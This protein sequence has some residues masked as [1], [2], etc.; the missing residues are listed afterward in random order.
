MNG[1]RKQQGL[2]EEREDEHAPVWFDHDKAGETAHRT[3]RH[4]HAHEGEH[5][6]E[7][8][9]PHDHEHEHDHDQHHDHEHGQDHDHDEDH[10]GGH[11][12]DHAHGHGHHHHHTPAVGHGRAF[13]LAVVLNVVIVVVQAIYGVLAHSTALLADAGHNL[14]DVL[15][16]LLAWG[17]AWLA[18]R[19]PSARYTFGFGSSSILASLANAALLLVACGAIIMEAVDRLIS[20]APV[21]GFDVFV[22]ATLGMVVNGFSAWLFMRGQKED[23]NI[24]GAFL[25]MAA[26]AGVSAAVAVS[27]LVILATGMTWIDPVMSILV[28]LVILYGTWGL[29]RESV[30]LALAAVP[31]GVDMERIHAFLAAQDGVTDVHDLHVWALSTTGN[32]L[33]VHLVMP[34]G[35]PGDDVLDGIVHTLGTRYRMKH[36]TLQ[37]DM[38]TSGHRCALDHPPYPH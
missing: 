6:H 12:H 36:V 8:G 26:D 14:S 16:L 3:G 11:G 18:T 31:Q 1:E 10:D 27:G 37:V 25:H 17:A 9:H 38:G 35:H 19:R 20:P 24:R 15:G 32:A 13:A 23:L 4:G 28:V 29:L 21:A 33:S 7:A 2:A 34:A 30:R 22:V 5:V